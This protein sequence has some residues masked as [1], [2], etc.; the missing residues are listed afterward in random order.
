[1]NNLEYLQNCSIDEFI[2]EIYKDSPN[3][4][5]LKFI[6]G[7][8]FNKEELKTYLESDI[9][10]TDIYVIY[11]KKHHLFYTGYEY[12]MKHERHPYVQ[13][14]PSKSDAH[15]FKSIEDAVCELSKLKNYGYKNLD[16]TPFN[17]LCKD[18]E[19]LMFSDCYGECSK[20]HKGIVNP[21]DTCDYGIRRYTNV[22]K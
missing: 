19:H 10:S 7:N 6:F 11:D 12:H 17:V 18:C 22:N 21:D 5:E 16:I 3:G 20:A 1:M 8:Y 2:N 4:C 9:K 13:F 15:I 14:L